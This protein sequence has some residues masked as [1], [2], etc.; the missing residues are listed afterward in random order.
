MPRISKNS[1]WIQ[2]GKSGEF[3]KGKLLG[4]HSYEKQRKVK[5]KAII[6]KAMLMRFED[7]KLLGIEKYEILEAVKQNLSKFKKGVIVEVK[8]GEMVKIGR[9]QSLIH[10]DVKVNNELMTWKRVWEVSDSESLDV[11][12]FF[13]LTSAK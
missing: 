12:E 11:K 3:Y 7:E 8:R 10:F 2:L 13:G 9:G 5:G 4:F 6:V 1:A